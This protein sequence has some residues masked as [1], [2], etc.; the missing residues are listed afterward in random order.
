MN[1]IN[2]LVM[3]V[4]L[5]ASVF[6]FGGAI[7]G[8]IYMPQI[9]TNWD[10][11]VFHQQLDNLDTFSYECSDIE[12]IIWE[13]ATMEVLNICGEDPIRN[14]DLELT[15]AMKKGYLD[16]IMIGKSNA[17][18]LGLKNVYHI[19]DARMNG[20][21]DAAITIRLS[22]GDFRIYKQVK[23]Y[24]GKKKIIEWV[25]IDAYVDGN[26]YSF[27]VENEGIFAAVKNAEE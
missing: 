16:I 3:L 13:P 19:I 4:L 24:Q 26:D 12:R 17:D 7:G 14:I 23:T 9:K 22:D 8:I 27:E 18:Y 25:D 20:N 5:A 15:S 1:K 11:Y 6:A 2:I 21:G 10:N